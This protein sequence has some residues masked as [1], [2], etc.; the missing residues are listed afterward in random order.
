MLQNG[1]TFN[2]LGEWKRTS[3]AVGQNHEGNLAYIIMLRRKDQI[4][5]PT[6]VEQNLWTQILYLY[7]CALKKMQSIF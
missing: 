7:V 2:A 4:M 5:K 1:G 3:C 6:T